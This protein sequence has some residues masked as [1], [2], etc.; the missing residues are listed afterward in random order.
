MASALVKRSMRERIL[1]DDA[2]ATYS[3]FA[4]MADA[5]VASTLEAISEIDVA[6]L[7]AEAD[8]VRTARMADIRARLDE[9]DA[10]IVTMRE[11]QAG[12]AAEP[13]SR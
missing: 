3:A 5:Y 4:D 6:T 8:P 7:G 11:L 2:D 9:L 1:G 12:S 13:R 10:L